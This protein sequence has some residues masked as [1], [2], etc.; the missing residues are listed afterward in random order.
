MIYMYITLYLKV[1]KLIFQV[2]TDGQCRI[3]ISEDNSEQIGFNHLF[4]DTLSL[5]S[6][7]KNLGLLEK[8]AESSSLHGSALVNNFKFNMRRQY[9]MRFN[10]DSS[11][12]KKLIIYEDLKYLLRGLLCKTAQK[13]DYMN[14]LRNTIQFTWVYDGLF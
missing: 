3:S 6:F 9:A 12:L 4:K 1:L 5:I 7:H 13:R 8:W 14:L 2:N 10:T 11:D